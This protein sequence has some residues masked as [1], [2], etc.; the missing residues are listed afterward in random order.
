MGSTGGKGLGHPIL[1]VKADSKQNE[2]VRDQQQNEAD[3][4]QYPTISIYQHFLNIGV[5]A[6]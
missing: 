5:R 2:R 1:R 3:G 4:C 6:G